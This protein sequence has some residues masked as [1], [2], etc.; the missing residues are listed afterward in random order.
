MSNINGIIWVIQLIMGIVAG[1]ATI[2]TIMM[3]GETKGETITMDG[4]IIIIII[5]TTT[6]D[7]VVII[8]ETINPKNKTM[9][10]EII[11]EEIMVVEEI[12]II[13]IITDGGTNLKKMMVGE[14]KEE[15]TM[16]GAII[17]ITT[18]DGVTR[19]EITTVG[20]IKEE[21]ITMDG[22][23]IN[24]IKKMMVGE[25]TLAATIMEEISRKKKM[26]GE[27]ILITNQTLEILLL[28]DG[29][30]NLLVHQDGDKFKFINFIKL[31]HI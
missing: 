26:D 28:Q 16:A 31:I 14:I 5:I 25:I 22:V 27:A 13:I 4:V 2:I 17:I 24:Q 1:V 12:T 6:M 3:V 29:E 20:E 19:V 9:D 7:G 10:G 8:G 11:L 15:I 18:M 21:T 30:I 23:I